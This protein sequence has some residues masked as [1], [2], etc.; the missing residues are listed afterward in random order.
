VHKI[1]SIYK[2]QSRKYPNRYYI[3]SSINVK[4]RWNH[5]LN[6]LRNNV[7][8]SIKLQ[9]HY[10]KYGES[11]LEFIILVGCD[12]DRIIE[13]E[14]YF[15]DACNPYFN[16][17]PTAGTCTNMVRSQAAIDKQR[18][19]M[20]GKKWTVEARQRFSELRK[21]IPKSEEHRRKLSEANK[22]KPGRRPSEEAIQRMS[23]ERK[24]KGNPMYGKKPWN[25]KD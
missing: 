19:S 5:H 1:I 20:L 6:D 8:H 16:C 9:R 15:L 25:K 24:G 4:K 11:D 14:Q 10:N 12:K 17:C 2:I 23:E 22:G 21:G 13:M 18:K 3:G 7:H